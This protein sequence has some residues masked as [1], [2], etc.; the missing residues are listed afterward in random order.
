MGNVCTDHHHKKKCTLSGK[1]DFQKSISNW[2][3]PALSNH[4]MG[5]F[6]QVFLVEKNALLSTDL[7]AV[8]S[9]IIS[10]IRRDCKTKLDDENAIISTKDKN[11]F[12]NF[13]FKFSLI[14]A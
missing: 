12:F 1:G 7:K 8:I 2:V 13:N 10:I 3:I 6:D 4:M 14:Q 11:P 9:I 5:L